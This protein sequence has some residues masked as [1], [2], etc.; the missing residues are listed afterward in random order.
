M[1][2]RRSLPGRPTAIFE[3]NSAAFWPLV[4][5]A[6]AG[7]RESERNHRFD[8]PSAA[9]AGVP[10]GGA[11]RGHRHLSIPRPG[12]G[13]R[14]DPGARLAGPRPLW[15]ARGPAGTG[16][17]AIRAAA[18]SD[19]A[20]LDW[21]IRA[22]TSSGSGRSRPPTTSGSATGHLRSV[23]PR[24]LR[25]DTA[26]SATDRGR[27]VDD[28]GRVEQR[29]SPV[30]GLR[31]RYEELSPGGRTAVIAAPRCRPSSSST[32][33]G[34][35]GATSPVAWRWAFI[36]R[37]DLVPRVGGACWLSV[38]SWSSPR[39]HQRVLR[40]ALLQLRHRRPLVER[41]HPSHTEVAITE[42]GLF[43][44]EVDRP[45]VEYVGLLSAQ[46]VEDLRNHGLVARA[47]RARLLGGARAPWVPWETEALNHPWFLP[48]TGP[49]T[50]SGRTR[51]FKRCGSTARPSHRRG[52]GPHGF[53]RRA[54]DAARRG[55]RVPGGAGAG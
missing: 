28:T 55:P 8:P 48:P 46:S 18:R 6:E 25:V 36:R 42:F 17:I 14:E 19:L 13:G 40:L 52:S 2:R 41:Q 11:H 30:A 12:H 26:R 32:S 45:L 5:L 23:R 7:S 3:P 10:R 47:E 1:R 35:R 9:R 27:S 21:R 15:C 54:R 49:C 20:D 51:T 34:S 50:R 43:G 44:W 29:R 4:M 31:R 37:T 24:V 16:N 33:V 38:R 39:R 22:T 53:E